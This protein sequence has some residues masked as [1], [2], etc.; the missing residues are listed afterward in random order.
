MNLDRQYRWYKINL[1]GANCKYRDYYFRGATAG[2]VKVAGAFETA[3]EAEDFLL[4]NTVLHLEDPQAEL[5][6]TMERLYAE[7]C[8]RS[9]LLT[10]DNLPFQDALNFLKSD[11]GKIESAAV[12]T[13]PSLDLCKLHNA[14]PTHYSVYLL[15]GRY[16]FES[17]Y[18]VPVEQAFQLDS[19]TDATS[20][21][22]EGYT[23]SENSQQTQSHR[24]G[25]KEYATQVETFKLSA[26]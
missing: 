18:G 24:V 12:I 2:E 22:Q 20:T 17:L 4:K 25:N 13:V 9:A 1:R 21:L 23:Y 3:T 14:D 7:I 15:L 16:L 5:A 8:K 10:E 26:K 19:P 6:Y 11:I